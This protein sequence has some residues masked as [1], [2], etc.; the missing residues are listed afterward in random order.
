[1]A[2]DD[3][4]LLF[5]EINIVWYKATTWRDQMKDTISAVVKT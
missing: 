4:F 2:D 3:L 5:T 1:M